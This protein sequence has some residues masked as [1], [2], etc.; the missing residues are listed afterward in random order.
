MYKLPCEA[1]ALGVHIARVSKKKP[2]GPR[3]SQRPKKA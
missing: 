2:E 1:M 3:R